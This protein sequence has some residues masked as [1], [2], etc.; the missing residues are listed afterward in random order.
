MLYRF[1][2]PRYS[3]TSYRTS[4][5]LL[6]ARIVFGSLFMVHGLEK[7]FL[8][9]QLADVFPDP[10]GIGHEASLVMAIFAELFCSVAFIFGFLY[11]LAML[12][13]IFTMAIALFV[14]HANDTFAAK[15]LALVYMLVFIFLYITGPGKYA[16]DYFIARGRL[17]PSPAV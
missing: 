14:I 13:M 15:E 10:L 5:V 12:P 7:L 16:L 6:G 9:Q 8:F 2:F 11:R 1:L 17:V 3:G 4:L